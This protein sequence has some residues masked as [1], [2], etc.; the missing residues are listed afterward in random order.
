MLKG[1]FWVEEGRKVIPFRK[2][3]IYEQTQTGS[4]KSFVDEAEKVIED[5]TEEDM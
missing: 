2:D 4:K 5:E 1:V 3:R